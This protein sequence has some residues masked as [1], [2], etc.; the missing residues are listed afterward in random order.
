MV[1]F[2]YV[3]QYQYSADHSSQVQVRIPSIHG[4]YR[5]EDAKGK[6]I[7]NY[8]EDADLPWYMSLQLDHEPVDGE[9]VA[10]ISMSGGGTGSDFLVIGFTGA[11]YSSET[12]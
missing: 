7:R 12:I 8:V 6:T 3:K 9:V 1:V 11:S 10:L 2:G 4:P 5:R